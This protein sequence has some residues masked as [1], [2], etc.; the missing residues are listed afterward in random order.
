MEFPGHDRGYLKRERVILA[1][2]PAVEPVEERSHYVVVRTYPNGGQDVQ[3]VVDT[4]RVEGKAAWVE[5]EDILRF[6]PYTAE[7]QAQLQA[8]TAQE[9]TDAMLIDHELRLTM[10]ELEGN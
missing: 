1:R 3:K 9:D 5:Y 4:A 8:P 6:Y 10:L 2:H 7:E